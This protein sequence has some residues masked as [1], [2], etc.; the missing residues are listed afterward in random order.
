MLICAICIRFRTFRALGFRLYFCWIFDTNISNGI[1]EVWFL[2]ADI[3]CYRNKH[4]SVDYSSFLFIYWN[5]FLNRCRSMKYDNLHMSFCGGWN[6]LWGN[7]IRNVR[8]FTLLRKYSFIH[9]LYVYSL[10]IALSHS[11]LVLNK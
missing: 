9:N 6:S 10:F 2:F 5:I 11:Y 1:K 7:S 3:Y 8:S 4:L